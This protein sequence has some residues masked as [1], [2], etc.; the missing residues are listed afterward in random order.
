MRTK[1]ESKRQGEKGAPSTGPVPLK[2]LELRYNHLLGLQGK[3]IYPKSLSAS[4]IGLIKL[5]QIELFT[6]IIN[7]GATNTYGEVF[8]MIS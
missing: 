5:Q 2:W 8:P 7:S 6:E 1:R 4:P 3:E